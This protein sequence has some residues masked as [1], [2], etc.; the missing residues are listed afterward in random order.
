[1]LRSCLGAEICKIRTGTWALKLLLG[2]EK[3][4]AVCALALFS[5]GKGWVVGMER[6]GGVSVGEESWG[7]SKAIREIL[8]LRKNALFFVVN[9]QKSNGSVFLPFF[10]VFECNR[11]K[12]LGP[13]VRC[14]L[15][16]GL[17][18][19][20]FDF[21]S[22]AHKLWAGLQRKT[23]PGLS[24]LRVLSRNPRS[25]VSSFLRFPNFVKS[26]WI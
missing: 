4:G 10:S 11:Q 19:F 6:A 26:P 18:F 20:P 25:T 3:P 15:Q 1:M 22:K 13:V 23:H 5:G 24:S 16:L 17:S 9:S 8:G 12:L 14:S 2:E 7:G 21:A